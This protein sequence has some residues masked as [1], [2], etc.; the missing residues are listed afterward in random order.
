MNLY[1]NF[2]CL[3]IKVA[4]SEAQVF[5]SLFSHFVLKLSLLGI[6]NIHT[7]YST[8]GFLLFISLGTLL[9]APKTI[10]MLHYSQELES[11]LILVSQ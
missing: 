4:Y 2:E 9:D 5:V 11:L 7:D 8:C 10:L 1:Y 3:S 6:I